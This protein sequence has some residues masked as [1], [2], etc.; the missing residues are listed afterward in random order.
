MSELQTEN[1]HETDANRHEDIDSKIA[2]FMADIDEIV[3]GKKSATDDNHSEEQSEWKECFDETSKS[4]YYWNT[5]TNECSWEPPLN[6]PQDYLT[7]KPEN[8][9]N[10]IDGISKKKRQQQ[11]TM[12]NKSPKKLKKPSLIAEYDSSE[13][14]ASEEEEEEEENDDDIDELLNQVLDKEENKDKK[15]KQI[16]LYPLFETDSRAAIARL[17][18]MGDTRTE[19]STLRLQIETRL[20]DCLSGHLSKS[21]AVSKLEQA[22]IQIEEFEKLLQTSTPLPTVTEPLQAP[23]TSSDMALLLSLPPPPPPPSPPPLSSN[24]DDKTLQLFYA[25]LNCDQHES[26]LDTETTTSIMK[27]EQQYHNSHHHLHHHHHPH[28]YKDK[29]NKPAKTLPTDL[30]QKWTHAR[31]ELRGAAD[32]DDS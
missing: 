23:L 7:E 26:I 12:E 20:E 8:T 27:S 28:P 32:I 19:I 17:N 14:E 13:S 16:D 22:L 5:V 6:T 10:I 18:D 3:L 30:I 2:D 15:Q 25:Q 21:Y 11:S 31:Q 4:I 24:E 1:G 29:K 9:T